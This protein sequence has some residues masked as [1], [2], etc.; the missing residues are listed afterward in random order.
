[1]AQA[2]ADGLLMQKEDGTWEVTEG[3]EKA[4]EALGL[5]ADAAIRFAEELGDGAE[6]LKAYGLSVKANKE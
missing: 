3:S 2:L 6:E 5:T 1:M 4:I